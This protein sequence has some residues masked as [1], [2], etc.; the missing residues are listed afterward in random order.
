MGAK[1][2]NPLIVNARLVN[3]VTCLAGIVITISGIIIANEP[4][5]T[6]LFSIGCSLI[7]TAV[8]ILISS[9]YLLKLRKIEEIISNWGLDG[10][11][12]TRSEMNLDS[13]AEF[14]KV[15]NQ[16][17]IMAFGL[18]S[19][20]NS[21]TGKSLNNK[22]AAGLK[23]RILTSNP[24][25]PYLKVRDY[26][27]NKKEGSTSHSINQLIDW[28]EE[29]KNGAPNSQNVQIK[30]YDSLPQGFYWRQD[31]CMYIGPYLYGK[32]SQKTITYKFK[33]NSQGFEYYKQYFEELWNSTSFIIT[34]RGLLSPYIVLNFNQGIIN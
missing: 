29:L 7:A 3:I 9:T 26:E 5:K 4:W 23:V 22:I 2:S 8:A 17:D 32:I 6:I 20:R 24:Q 14:L 25:S 21:D 31:D 19:F 12:T 15:K 18:E 10:I 16:L 27:E 28:V 1:K 33:G 34:K 13:D 11:F 30:L